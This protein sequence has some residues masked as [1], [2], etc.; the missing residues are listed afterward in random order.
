SQG[1][2]FDGDLERYAY[3]D[4]KGNISVRLVAD[5]RELAW[6]PGEGPDAPNTAAP[7]LL[8][9]PDGALLVARHHQASNQAANLRIWDWRLGKIIF[10]PA[11]SLCCLSLDF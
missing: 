9:S 2:A 5:G 3:S 7:D 1:L 8:F 11:F 6:L 4:T 10:Q